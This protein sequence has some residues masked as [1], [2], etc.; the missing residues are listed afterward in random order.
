MSPIRTAIIGLSANATTAWASKAHLPYLLSPRG[1]ERYKIVALLNSTVDSAQKAINYYGLPAETRAYGDAAALAADPEVELVVCSTRV[2][3]HYDTILPSLHAGKAAF[4]E[5]PLA[6]NIDDV[7]EL[8]RIAA[9]KKV[10][11]VVGVQG[12]VARIFLKVKEVADSGRIGRVLS[13][14][15]IASGGS[16]SRDTLPVGLKYFTDRSI[17]G[18]TFT[19]GFGHCEIPCMLDVMGQAH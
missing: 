2:D 3:K 11:T 17:G 19:I 4:V 7:R 9:E 13:S 16:N 8:A 15:V 6:G 12:R 14:E 10:R 1:R 18:N 5:W